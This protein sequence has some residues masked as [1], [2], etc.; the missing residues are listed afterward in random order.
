MKKIILTVL[1]LFLFLSLWTSP[2]LAT[3]FGK[4]KITIG[5][6]VSVEGPQTT[7]NTATAS[8]PVIIGSEV[9]KDTVPNAVGQSDIMTFWIDEHGR[10][11]LKGAN[12]A[13]GTIDTSPVSRGPIENGYTQLID[14]TLDNT[15]MSL[16]SSAFFVGDKN[17]LGFYFHVDTTEVNNT[18]HA[19]WWIEMSP[20]NS[21][22][23]TC[24]TILMADGSDAPVRYLVQNESSE[25]QVS[26]ATVYPNFTAQWIK[27]YVKGSGIDADDTIVADGFLMWAK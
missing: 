26:T 18:P 24:D 1:F 10:V 16:Y 20:D 21:T 25:S 4:G 11:V 12:I 19:K 7:D 3:E 23:A 5:D 8:R 2:I 27:I 22:Y 14:G 13:Q 15:P 17:K 6:T 9:W